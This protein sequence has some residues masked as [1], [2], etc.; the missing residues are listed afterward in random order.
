MIKFHISSHSA[1]V[2]PRRQ[3]ASWLDKDNEKSNLFEVLNP[4]AYATI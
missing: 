3:Q 2:L 1:P 4:S